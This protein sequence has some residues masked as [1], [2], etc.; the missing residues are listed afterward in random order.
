MYL[1]DSHCHLDFSAFADDREAMLARAQEAH[2][3]E[4]VVPGVTAAQWPVLTQL[5]HQ[6]SGWHLA[7]GLHPYFVEAHRREHLAELEQW[8]SRGS[9]RG[10]DAGG[11]G[12]Q[13][14][15]CSSSN[16]HSHNN[17]GTTKP[18]VAVGEIG[19][20]ATCP[21]HDWQRELLRGQLQLAARHDLPV[22]LH[23]RK[24]LDELMPLVKQAGVTGIVHAF[25]G[26]A[27]QAKKWAELGFL[28][29]V[30]GVVTYPR[31]RK[32]RAALQ[33]V[34]TSALALET[35]SPDMPV[36]GFQGE[37]NEPARLPYALS[38][39]AELRQTSIAELAQQ[40]TANVRRV[41]RLPPGS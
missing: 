17:Q 36:Q 14:A 31:A 39:L 38:A 3:R 10:E 20:D 33:A 12:N 16:S 19:L 18:P 5:A 40:T 9:D 35:D 37:R 1:I 22:I 24:T 23:H 13:R 21:D 29:G 34:P 7:Y 27:Q 11:R 6:H 32:T 15:H 30:G 26:S 4:F 8:L 28:L 25:S 41:L 2:I